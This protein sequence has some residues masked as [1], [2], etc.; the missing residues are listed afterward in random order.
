MYGQI[1]WRNCC[2]EDAR[3]ATESCSTSAAVATEGI[4][5]DGLSEI[6]STV[7]HVRQLPT[8]LTDISLPQLL[9]SPTYTSAQSH[10][11]RHSASDTGAQMLTTP[12]SYRASF[13]R[14]Q[15]VDIPDVDSCRHGNVI[16]HSTVSVTYKRSRVLI[17]SLIDSHSAMQHRTVRTLPRCTTYLISLRT[18]P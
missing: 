12:S 3:Q 10:R 11:V 5:A 16:P 17:L 18:G 15:P 2:C 8:R 1:N 7:N 13:S 14:L 9:L 6:S 4:A